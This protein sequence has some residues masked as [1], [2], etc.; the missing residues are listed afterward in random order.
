MS[1]N[2]IKTQG[3]MVWLVICIYAPG[4]AAIIHIP[5]DYSTIQAGIDASADRD[6]ILVEPDTYVENISIADHSI[7]LGSLYL[8]TGD[9]SFISSTILDGDSLESVIKI[10][11]THFYDTATVITVFT[12]RNGNPDYGGGGIDLYGSPVISHNIIKDNVATR[13]G[14]IYVGGSPVIEHNLITNNYVTVAGGGIVSYGGACIIINNIITENT[15][16]HYGGAIHIETSDV[17]TI[18]DNI[19][20]NNTANRG[21]I[22]FHA[23]G[24]GGRMI[25][26][27]IAGNSA[28]IS[29]AIDF[30]YVQY[31]YY[32]EDNTIVDNS[33]NVD[34][35]NLFPDCNLTLINNIIWNNAEN[36]VV[37]W[38]DAQAT[39]AYNDIQN[40]SDGENNIDDDPLFCDPESMDYS[41]AENSPCI[42]AGIDGSDIGA[43]GIGC[44]AT[45]VENFSFE[46]P[47]SFKLGRNYPNPFN[48][49]TTI[50]FEL[51]RPS[52][53]KL[54]IYD[55]IGQKITAPVNNYLEIG[56]HH[57]LFDASDLASGIYFY[58]LQ[59]G[60][61]H[62]TK[63]MLLIK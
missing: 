30:E 50:D 58:R 18:S 39:V 52:F 36:E 16:V 7:T 26:N 23:E 6:T 14:G 19:I 33:Y 35:L 34:G 3:L 2:I 32:L 44:E 24:S 29:S 60:Q 28:S 12:I 4:R 41:L 53:V 49:R 45:E 57:I 10:G 21:A 48:A 55:I 5:D 51:S 1:S 42:G 54:D 17:A 61:Y 37:I 43:F 40:Y 56:Q 47:T 15:S 31:Y 62:D 13:G 8:T 22:C 46:Q 11:T 38:E 20:T 63:K 27:L 59:C 25:N 9:T